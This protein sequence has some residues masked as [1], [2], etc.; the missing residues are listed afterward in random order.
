MAPLRV[1]CAQ[2][3]LFLPLQKDTWRVLQDF[4]LLILLPED[5]ASGRG[6]CVPGGKKNQRVC[7]MPFPALVTQCTLGSRFFMVSHFQS[8]GKGAEVLGLH[9]N[10]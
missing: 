2:L 5:K 9:S 3:V 10:S 6:K 4:F 7:E 1:D 8:L